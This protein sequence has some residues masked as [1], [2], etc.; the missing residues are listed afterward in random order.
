MWWKLPSRPDVPQE[1]ANKVLVQSRHTCCLC[2]TNRI[3]AQIHHADGDPSNNDEDNLVP[4]CPNCHARVEAEYGMTRNYTPEQL[5]MY[6]DA[7][8]R[9]VKEAE[10]TAAL[11]TVLEDSIEGTHLTPRLGELRRE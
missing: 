10:E 8:V 6:R 11:Q 2:H 4:L 3:T 5:K 7:W 1:V 9:E